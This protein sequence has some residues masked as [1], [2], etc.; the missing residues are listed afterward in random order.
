MTNDSAWLLRHGL[1]FIAGGLAYAG[2][3]DAADSDTLAE[4]LQNV[5]TQL[6]VILAIILGGA[7]ARASV[8]NKRK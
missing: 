4:A 5:A 7:G 8:L 2:Y 1:T 3:V 6:E